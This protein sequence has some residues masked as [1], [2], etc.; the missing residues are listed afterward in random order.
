M[1]EFRLEEGKRMKENFL[2]RINEIYRIGIEERE[3]IKISC[4]L[5][6]PPV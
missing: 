3:I 5:H 1:T 2:D 6:V 4:S